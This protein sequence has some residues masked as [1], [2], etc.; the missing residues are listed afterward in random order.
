MHNLNPHV[1]QHTGHII[2]IQL[3]HVLSHVSSTTPAELDGRCSCRE[4]AL[5][6]VREAGVAPNPDL[7]RLYD[8]MDGARQLMLSKVES[9]CQQK[10]A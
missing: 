9:V 5:K 8:L 3:N 4:G 10:L 2:I 7:A 1:V 6:R